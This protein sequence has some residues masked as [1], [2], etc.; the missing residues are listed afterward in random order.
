MLDLNFNQVKKTSICPKPS[1][2]LSGLNWSTS[3]CLVEVI[4]VT[5]QHLAIS[6]LSSNFISNVGLTRN[7]MLVLN[8][9]QVKKT[10]VCQKLSLMLSRLNSRP[11]ACLAEVITVTPQHLAI[12][13]LSSNFKATVALSRNNMLDLYFNQVKKT[14]ICRKLALMQS[15]LELE[16]LCVLSRSDKRNTTAPCD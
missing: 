2:M 5:P 12:N 3:A 13:P 1:L 15:R 8:F 4:T 14:S 11:S 9:N 6:P 16:T 10:S 7:K